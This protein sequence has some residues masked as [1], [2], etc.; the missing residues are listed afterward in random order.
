[1]RGKKAMAILIGL[2]LMMAVPASAAGGQP[3]SQPA[4]NPGS[5]LITVNGHVTQLKQP[6]VNLNGR[7][8]LAIED[9]TDLLHAK[10]QTN[11]KKE[12][13]V[14]LRTGETLTFQVNTNRVAVNNEWSEI[15]QGAILHNKEIYLPLRWVVE[16]A[17]HELIWN[18]QT[19]T[20][21]IVAPEG[22]DQ[23]KQV[24]FAS[25]SQ[26]EKDFVQQVKKTAGL[27]KQGDLYV[28]SRG[29]SPNPGYGIE[30]VGTEWSWEQLKVYVK[31]TKPEQGRM[32]AQVISYP[33]VT[34]RVT[35]P[36]YT[37]VVLLDADTKKPLFEEAE[38][39]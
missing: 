31:L 21:D 25:L 34:A 12:V 22:Y 26:E 35:L 11:E 6:S 36:P 20:V 14:T 8:Y 5:A 3:A 15:G 18:S 29:Q 24:D 27:H 13:V 1:M 28:I 33:F 17:G 32:Y 30:I 7:T 38:G 39:K 23:F 4:H 10:W 19:R 37:T 2:Q 16:R 9:L